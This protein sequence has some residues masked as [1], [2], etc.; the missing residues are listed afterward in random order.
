MIIYNEKVDVEAGTS[1]D[2][3]QSPLPPPTS[4]RTP[5]IATNGS[6]RPGLLHHYLQRH[7]DRPGTTRRTSGDTAEEPEL[8]D[9]PPPY[10]ASLSEFS[11]TNHDEFAKLLPRSCPPISYSAIHSPFRAVSSQHSSVP[12]DAGDEEPV[13][14]PSTLLPFS[15]LRQIGDIEGTWA[16]SSDDDAVSSS[17]EHLTAVRSLT[18]SRNLQTESGNIRAS[19]TVEGSLPRRCT[20]EATT[21]SG[22]VDLS[23]TR[24]SY[25]SRAKIHIRAKSEAHGHISINLPSDFTGVVRVG[26]RSSSYLHPIQ[27]DAP[28]TTFVSCQYAQDELGTSTTEY[29][30]GDVVAAGYVKGMTDDEWRGDIVEAEAWEGRV[31]INVPPQNIGFVGTLISTLSPVF[32]YLWLFWSA[33]WWS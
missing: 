13:A 18:R 4:P 3:N 15:P 17:A 30:V 21:G 8:Q 20:V 31:T 16:L 32:A 11:N 28:C 19:I 26:R 23:A 1:S 33:R 14:G 6:A 22:S 12:L 24:S 2:S 5:S 9:Q 25:L 29:F 27:L 10:T 7:L